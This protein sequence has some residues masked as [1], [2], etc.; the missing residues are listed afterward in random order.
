[1][2]VRDVGL[3]IAQRAPFVERWL[4]SVYNSFPGSV[5]DTPASRAQAYFRGRNNVQFVQIGAYDGIAGDP[6]RPLILKNLSWSGVL[7]EPQR[8]AF[9][10]LERNYSGQRARLHFING[11]VSDKQGGT[12]KLF[13]VPEHE[14]LAHGLPEWSREVASSDPS[15]IQKHFPGVQ[16]ISENVRAYRFDELADLLPESRV[17][18]VV[19]D[20]EGAEKR[21]IESIDF[22]RHSIRFLIF[23][24][25]HMGNNDFYSVSEFLRKR[26]MELKQFGRDTVAWRRE[27]F[28]SISKQVGQDCTAIRAKAEARHSALVFH[29]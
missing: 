15:H 12:E 3:W 11:S 24:H 14:I 4:R 29:L 20:V 1:M 5:H 22:E 19:M 8:H 13:F 25:K 18:V 21:L 28:Q 10:S 17:D 27:D 7:V 16:L 6:I 23:E 9:E 26:K 2:T